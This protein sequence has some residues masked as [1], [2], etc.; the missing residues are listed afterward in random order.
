MGKVKVSGKTATGIVG[1]VVS[2]AVGGLLLWLHLGAK[3]EVPREHVA[4]DRPDVFV[5]ADAPAWVVT[6]LPRV[7]DFWRE[8][9]RV[10]GRVTRG[11]EC[12]ASCTVDGRLAAVPCRPGAITVALADQ[13]FDADHGDETFSA[14]DP[15][16]N[17]LRWSTVM[18]PEVLEP[19]TEYDA[20]GMAIWRD[21]PDD[22]NALV[23]AHGFGHADGLGHST[24]AI[25][26]D[27]KVVAHK[28][29]EVMNPSVW[30]AGWGDKGL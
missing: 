9:G 22:V 15:D 7:L 19:P 13:G 4:M 20:D 29:G 11:A 17:Q 16:S 1:G 25:T 23:L 12:S 6:E 3:V 8:H 30:G 21:P 24:T 14:W 18:V 10:Y 28:T 26:K 27:K 5:C 2:A